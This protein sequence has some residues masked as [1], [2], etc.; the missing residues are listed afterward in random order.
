MTPKHI[1]P[2]CPACGAPIV[3]CT[4]PNADPEDFRCSVPCKATNP[5]MLDYSRA[6]LVEYLGAD[7]GNA[8]ADYYGVAPTG[9]AA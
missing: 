3:K 4:D 5:L 8:C 9:A 6:E 2:T 1:K 7:E